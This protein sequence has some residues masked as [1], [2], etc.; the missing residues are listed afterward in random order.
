MTQDL[1]GWDDGWIDHRAF[2]APSLPPIPPRAR[3]PHRRGGPAPPPDGGAAHLAQLEAEEARRMALQ[4]AELGAVLA[5]LTRMT[6]RGRDT[7]SA[8][9]AKQQPDQPELRPQAPAPPAE[10]PL[11]MPTPRAP[12]RPPPDEPPGASDGQRPPTPGGE[13]DSGYWLADA[14]NLHRSF[15]PRL[16]GCRSR[17]NQR[18]VELHYVCP[19]L[20]PLPSDDEE[21]DGPGNHLLLQWQRQQKLGRQ[22]QKPHRSRR[23]RPA[24]PGKRVL[25]PPCGQPGPNCWQQPQQQPRVPTRSGLPAVLI[26]RRQQ[27]DGAAGTWGAAERALAEASEPPSSGSEANARSRRGSRVSPECARRGV[28]AARLRLIFCRVRRRVLGRD[29]TLRAECPVAWAMLRE[30]YA[31]ACRAAVRDL[32]YARSRQAAAAAA[33]GADGAGLQEQPRAAAAAAPPAFGGAPCG[34]P[35]AAPAGAEGLPEVSVPQRDLGQ[36]AASAERAVQAVKSVI[37]SLSRQ[38]RGPRRSSMTWRGRAFRRHHPAP[39][40]QGR[41]PRRS[42]GSEP[43]TFWTL[44]HP[45]AAAPCPVTTFQLR[46]PGLLLA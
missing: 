5:E 35:A 16:R 9:Q 36:G 45:P 14:L 10:A 30:R 37:D 29:S 24:P 20:Y 17:R 25:L 13:A 19:T 31:L 21:G 33:A 27:A 22:V 43:H 15:V 28:V 32:T 26:R 40:C 12:P 6:P 4:R 41:R 8:A 2:C 38:H 42:L 7:P 3:E 39:P 1:L 34:A 44:P 46:S 11:A 18:P 23:H